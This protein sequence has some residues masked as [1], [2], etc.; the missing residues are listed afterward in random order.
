[1]LVK[2]NL[3]DLKGVADIFNA[4][5]PLKG[6]FSAI[7]SLFVTIFVLLTSFGGFFTAIFGFLYFLPFDRLVS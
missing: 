4:N 5:F 2:T 6:F 1:M 7:F 3:R